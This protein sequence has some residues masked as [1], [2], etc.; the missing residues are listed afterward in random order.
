[1]KVKNK[2]YV[3]VNSTSMDDRP[4]NSVEIESGFDGVFFGGFSSLALFMAILK[5]NVSKLMNI[6][7]FEMLIFV[8]FSD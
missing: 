2:P 6:A 4:A 5:Q 1:M 8:V 7:S 3:M